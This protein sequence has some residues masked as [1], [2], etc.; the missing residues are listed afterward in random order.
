MPEPTSRILPVPLDLKAQEQYGLLTRAQI[1]EELSAEQLRRR[2]AGGL[3]INVD[4]GVYRLAG[5]PRTWEQHLMTACLAVSDPVAISH[6]TAALLWGTDVVAKDGT[7]LVIPRERGVQKVRDADVHRL[8]LPAADI[9]SQK[10]IP[11]TT[12]A[13]TILDLST[14]VG[15]TQLERLVD[16]FLHRRILEIGDLAKR[17]DAPLPLPRFDRHVVSEIVAR[18][19][20]SEAANSRGAEWMYDAIVAAG[21]PAPVRHH[22]VTI[23]QRVRVIDCAYPEARIAV[24]FDGWSV[25]GDHTHFHGDRKR[26]FQFEMEG[27]LVLLVTQQWSSTELVNAVRAAIAQRSS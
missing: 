26:L 16:D 5:A 6:R 23:G 20:G 8:V 19:S 10:G 21:L 27:W 3:F 9:A 7:H 12:P 25:H 11:V 22:R 2:R 17:V 13:R 24:E 14:D 18:R 1:L 15:V 4:R